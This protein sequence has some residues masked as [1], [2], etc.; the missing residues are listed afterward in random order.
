MI[1]LTDHKGPKEKL[2]KEIIL[3]AIVL[4]QPAR[5]GS[6]RHNSKETQILYLP[7]V[8]AHHVPEVYDTKRM[9]LTSMTMMNFKT[10]ENQ[11]CEAQIKVKM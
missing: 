1:T 5:H 2:F 8:T 9:V 3:R 7:S 11:K 10:T 6:W 4:S